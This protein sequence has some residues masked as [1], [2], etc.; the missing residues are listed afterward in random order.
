MSNLKHSRNPKPIAK[1]TIKRPGHREEPYKSAG[2]L[3]K[4]L[5]PQNTTTTTNKIPSVKIYTG[6][7]PQILRMSQLN[8]DPN[9]IYETYGLIVSIGQGKFQC[10]R[11]IKLRSLEGRELE[12]LFFEIDLSLSPGCKI[13]QLIRCVGRFNEGKFYIIK[14]GPTNQSFI[15]CSN[16]LNSFCS[17]SMSSINK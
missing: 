14:I 8:S 2:K 9:I 1:P 10:E 5:K 13:N 17:F 4:Y 11:V 12:G 16:R 15:N 3:D 7:I 6:N